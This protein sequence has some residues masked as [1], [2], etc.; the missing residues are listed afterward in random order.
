MPHRQRGQR[1]T[2]PP[3]PGLRRAAPGLVSGVGRG[4]KLEIRS[5]PGQRPEQTRPVQ[6]ETSVAWA[7]EAGAGVSGGED[8]GGC[9]GGI[10]KA[11]GSHQTEVKAES[12]L[13]GGYPQQWDSYQVQGRQPETLTRCRGGG[14]SDGVIQWGSLREWEVAGLRLKAKHKTGALG[15]GPLGRMSREPWIRPACA[16]GI[17]SWAGVPADFKSVIRKKK[18]RL[19]SVFLTFRSQGSGVDLSMAFPQHSL[20]E[21]LL[22]SIR[23][24]VTFNSKVLI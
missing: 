23:N 11:I 14:R 4:R 17:S 8:F 10:I 2:F 21:Q 15:E 12:R 20:F 16:G 6:G 22:F 5:I 7:Q 18:V 19:L 3:R 13:K 24:H 9:L 1:G